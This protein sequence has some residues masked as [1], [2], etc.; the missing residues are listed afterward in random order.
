MYVQLG[1]YLQQLRAI[2]RRKP[3]NERRHIPTVK[4]LAEVTGVHPNS[5]SR[6]VN[7]YTRRL[8][9]DIAGMI[10]V[11]IRRCGFQI[12]VSDILAIKLPEDLDEKKNKLSEIL[13][14]Q[15]PPPLTRRQHRQ[16][17]GDE[18]VKAY[19]EESP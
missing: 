3:E 4:E 14:Q 6:I 12:E 18:F 15:P 11:H 17:P 8:N 16:F 9:L 7:G 1:S 10:L 13:S 2:E 5:I 19:E